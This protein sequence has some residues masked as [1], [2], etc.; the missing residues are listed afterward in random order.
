[1]RHSAA[2]ADSESYGDF[3]TRPY[4]LAHAQPVAV[5]VAVTVTVTVTVTVIDVDTDL[6]ADLDT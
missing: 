6:D 1:V 3:L 5:A 4:R 2:H